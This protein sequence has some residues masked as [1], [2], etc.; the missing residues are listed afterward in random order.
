MR[1]QKEIA[2]T[3][4]EQGADYVLQVN[5]KNDARRHG[6]LQGT[7]SAPQAKA[8]LQAAGQREPHRL[9]PAISFPVKGTTAEP[10]LQVRRS[11][12]RIENTLH[13]TLDMTCVKL[14]TSSSFLKMYRYDSQPALVPGLKDTLEQ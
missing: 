13:E 7:R 3:I 9:K 14:N 6:G 11:H 1:T 4:V 8:P 5:D 2:A 10:L 12:R